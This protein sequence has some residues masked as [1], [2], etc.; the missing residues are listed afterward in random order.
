[1][2]ISTSTTPLNQQNKDALLIFF[3]GKTALVPEAEQQTAALVKELTG[4]SSFKGEAG[5]IAVLPL[6][7]A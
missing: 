7:S 6:P 1:M 3:Q 5:Q 4:N 2:K